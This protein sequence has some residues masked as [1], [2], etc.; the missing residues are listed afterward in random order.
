MKTHWHALTRW[1]LAAAALT[2]LVGADRVRAAGELAKLDL[3]IGHPR[4]IFFRSEQPLLYRIP[5]EERLP[6]IESFDAVSIKLL[7]E[8]ARS[9]FRALIPL[10]ADLKKRKPAMPVL[11]HLDHFAT[12]RP[13]EGTRLSP[14]K[15]FKPYDPH[16]MFPGF[17]LYYPPSALSRAVDTKA[18]RLS[19]ADAK[20]FNPG[21]DARLVAPGAEGKPEVWRRSETVFVESVDEEKNL[22][23]VRRG[24]YETEASAFEAGAMI[25]PH[26][27][28]K[29][30]NP[31]WYWSYNFAPEG[32][33]DEKG[34]NC[35][36]WFADW[37]SE[38]IHAINREHGFRVIDGVEF[39]VTKFVLSFGGQPLEGLA[40]ATGR[41]RSPDVDLDGVGD[42]GYEDGAPTSGFG[43]IQTIARLR[44]NLG[45]D[46]LIVGDSIW[47]LWRPWKYANGMDNESFPD[48]RKAFRYSGALERLIQ[49]SQRAA[50]PRFNMIFNRA[51][52]DRL[53][54][55]KN[56]YQT[57]RHSAA[58]AVANGFW[59]CVDGLP[60][61]NSRMPDEYHAGADAK[62]HWLGRPVGELTR[63][64][65][66]RSGNLID[67]GAFDTADQVARTGVAS[68]AD[69]YVFEGPELA[70]KGAHSGPGCLRVRM[71]RLPRPPEAPRPH[72]ARFNLPFDCEPDTEYTFEFMARAEHDYAAQ[73]PSCEGVPWGATVALYSGKGGRRNTGQHAILIPTDDWRKFHI[74]VV[75]RPG[76]SAAMFSFELGAEPGTLYLDE[77]RVYEGSADAFYRRFEGG[78]VL[79]NGTRAKVAFDLGRIDSERR[80]RRL[81][82]TRVDGKWQSDPKVNNGE[83]VA[84]SA[85]IELGPFDGLFLAL[86]D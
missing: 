34:R 18:T 7:N 61:G 76:K 4:T 19:V 62:R 20:R 54:G 6:L 37:T 32:P 82:A 71:A 55:Q 21:D 35:A 45:D 29:Y 58:V 28:M 31:A 80:Y 8:A 84:P 73:E 47:T 51:K 50:E 79:V 77:A 1:T 33:R 65:Q 57:V 22:L 38:E 56:V 13:L 72:L 68:Q 48:I 52:E 15:T 3:Q 69:G 78:L 83:P 39:D 53:P 67:Y 40:D 63:L 86:A 74:T 46:F 24:Q 60:G 36:E 30:G 41:P 64:P 25:A 9:D 75:A 11:L 66:I 26:C 12:V 23:T 16:D 59:H 85:S 42:M 81:R 2:C 17:F 43:T 27:K 5:K 44:E 14:G 10:M 49:W 70:R